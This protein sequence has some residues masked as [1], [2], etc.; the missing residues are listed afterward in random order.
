MATRL[1][2]EQSEALLDLRIQCLDRHLGEIRA[3][4]A[5]L[6][7]GEAGAV[8][9]AVDA[10]R[11]LSSLEGCA[12]GR[13]LLARVPPPASPSQRERVDRLQSEIADVEALRRLGRYSRA[14]ERGREVAAAARQARLPSAGCPGGAPARRGR[15]SHG[16]R[17]RGVASPSPGCTRSAEAAGDDEHVALAFLDLAFVQTELAQ[18]REAHDSLELASAVFNRFGGHELL[19]CRISYVRGVLHFRQGGYEDAR[20]RFPEAI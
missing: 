18:Y 9:K 16:P 6:A 12:D 3:L 8:E 1:R 14:L 2:G 10:S 11:A 4:T 19:H 7:L 20:R 15:G 5:L 17:R 13:A